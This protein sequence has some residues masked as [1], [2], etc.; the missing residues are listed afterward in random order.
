V[1]RGQYDRQAAAQKRAAAES[2]FSK[3]KAI[4]PHP[5]TVPGGIGLLTPVTPTQAVEKVRAAIDA[6]PPE[7]G[8]Q[9]VPPKVHPVLG[10]ML[11]D[12]VTRKSFD[13]RLG[14]E[15]T[16]LSSVARYADAGKLEAV[17]TVAEQLRIAL[18]D[19]S[20]V[21]L[22]ENVK[23]ILSTVLGELS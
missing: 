1:G 12:P 15:I 13:A 16:R 9:F 11:H 10:R 21:A 19:A 5:V 22:S 4:E 2:L 23:S 7:A 20:T 14:A 18:R 3:P 6:P 17:R 8:R